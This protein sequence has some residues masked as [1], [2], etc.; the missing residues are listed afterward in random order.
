LQELLALADAPSRQLW[1]SL[2]L[3][4]TESLGHPLL[5]TEIA[6][7]YTSAAEDDVITFVGAEEAIFVTMH[8]ALSAS[9][10]V[11]VLWPAYQSLYE[12]A[13]SIGASVTLVPLDPGTWT[14]DPDAVL[15]APVRTRVSSSS[16]FR[17]VPP[18]PSRSARPSRI[19]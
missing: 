5:R 6:R 11:V 1:E 13:R 18:A 8:A 12:V 17:I 10:H 14:F 15:A 2:R 9:D 3:G 4:Y 7:L 16:I 19:A